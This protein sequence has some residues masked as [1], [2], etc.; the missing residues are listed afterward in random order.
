MGGEPWSSRQFLLFNVVWLAIILVATLG[1]ARQWRPAYVVTLFLAI[2][3]GIGNGL[4]HVALAIRA[5]GYFSGLYTAPFALL[6]GTALL[7]CHRPRRW[8]PHS[9]PSD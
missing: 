1:A 9:S 7:I 8:S 2:G 6:A 5:G 3:G 4:G